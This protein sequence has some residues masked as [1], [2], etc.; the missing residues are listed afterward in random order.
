DFAL[1]LADPFCFAD[2]TAHFCQLDVNHEHVTR[3]DWFP[4]ADVFGGHKIGDAADVL[5]I[6]HHQNTGRLR[7]RFKLKYARHNRMTWEVSLKVR[8]VDR[9]SFDSD[10]VIS[11]NFCNPVHHQKWIAVRQH[12]HHS[13]N[14]HCAILGNRV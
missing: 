1:H 14:I 10:D 2:H 13:L 12:S 11:L 5:G 6:S 8:L 9:D 3:M 4:P 7:H